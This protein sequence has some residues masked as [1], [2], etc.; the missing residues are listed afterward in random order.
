MYSYYLDFLKSL[1]KFVADIF[2]DIKHYQFNYGSYTL[3]HHKLYKEHVQEYP[4]CIINLSDITNEDNQAFKR[5]I[6]NKHSIQTAQLLASNHTKKES[7][8]MDFKWMILQFQIKINF[9]STADLLNY[10]N[11]LQSYF[12]KNFM[13]YSYTY[14]VLIEISKYTNNWEPTDTT[15]GLVYRAINQKVETFAQYGIE[16]IFRITNITQTKDVQTDIS[17]D[18]SLEVKIK[19]PNKIG[20]QSF[21]ERIVNGIEIVIAT[22]DE[23]NSLPILI[24]MDDDVISDRLSRLKRRYILNEKMIV[25]NQ[26]I[27]NYEEYNLLLGY[28]IG[29]YIV[30]DSTSV[31]AKISFTEIPLLTDD[32]TNADKKEFVIDLAD[33]LSYFQFSDLSNMQLMVF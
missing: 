3:L 6:G 21:D 7:V 23:F 15:E 29:I 8:L 20:N 13:F 28:P 12:P 1:K 11:V 24:D 2:P 31:D 33:D 14:N 32:Y 22:T 10:H 30:D 9:N 5:Y 19:V 4:M 25:N 17:L 27:L 18:I 26:L 16:P